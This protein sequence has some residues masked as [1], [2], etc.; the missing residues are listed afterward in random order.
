MRSTAGAHE[1]R[2]RLSWTSNSRT[3]GNEL[4]PA[5][6]HFGDT[7]TACAHLRQDAVMAIKCETAH[8][9]AVAV[10]RFCCGR[11]SVRGLTYFAR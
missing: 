2:L 5:N 10:T 9:Y 6:A 3:D 11:V 7:D 1:V 8:V 4:L